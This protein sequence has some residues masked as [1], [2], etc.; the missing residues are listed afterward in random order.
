MLE[1]EMLASFMAYLVINTATPKI[2][3]D[4]KSWCSLR[5]IK[6]MGEIRKELQ[7]PF[8]GA[9]VLN[10]FKMLTWLCHSFTAFLS[11]RFYSDLSFSILLLF[12][13]LHTNS[14]FLTIQEI[15]YGKKTRTKVKKPSHCIRKDLNFDVFPRLNYFEN[16]N[17]LRGWM[18]GKTK[19]GFTVCSNIESLVISSF[20]L[21]K[22]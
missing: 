13:S 10:L 14:D 5:W 3:L 12:F 1:D 22:Q 6:T 20:F 2:E 4:N 8:S 21:G 16:C 9:M 18:R 15:C 19:E 11:P 7:I 17:S